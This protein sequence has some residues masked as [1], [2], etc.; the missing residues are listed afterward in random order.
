M[1]FLFPLLLGASF[2][3]HEHRV[4]YTK[5]EVES[6]LGEAA[7][8]I[9]DFGGGTGFVVSPSGWILTNHHVAEQFGEVGWVALGWDGEESRPVKVRLAHTR[10]D[11]DLALYHTNANDLSWL[12]LRTT[13]P[14]KHEPVAVVGHPGGLPVQVS[15]GRVLTAELLARGVPSVEYDAQTNWGSSGSPVIDANGD[16]I[17][18]HWAWDAANQWNGWMLG[19]P[20]SEALAAWPEL[21]EVLPPS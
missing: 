17:A 18:I 7:D 13:A 11:L 1:L 8:A 10:P 2:L 16:V 15:Y 4:F 19:V 9:A 20:M 6:P 3:D 14:V 21:V 12:P 5:T